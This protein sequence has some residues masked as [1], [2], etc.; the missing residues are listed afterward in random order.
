LF[1]HIVVLTKLE[2]LEFVVSFECE[3]ATTTDKHCTHSSAFL[4]PLGFSIRD[5]SPV[6]ISKAL[7]IFRAPR[8]TFTLRIWWM[9]IGV[10]SLSFFYNKKQIKYLITHNS[11]IKKSLNKMF[12]YIK[13]K[14]KSQVKIN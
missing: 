1:I 6:N 8:L 11:I 7:G 14:E 5:S 10:P 3:C 13:T 2:F 4:P 9:S 12:I